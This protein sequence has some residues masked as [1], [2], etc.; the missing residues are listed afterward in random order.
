MSPDACSTLR[1]QHEV[2]RLDPLLRIEKTRRDAIVANSCF[3]PSYYQ[4]SRPDQPTTCLQSLSRL[5]EIECYRSP[6]ICFFLT[7]LS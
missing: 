2:R 4:V 6:S 1:A 5:N 3:S 7:Y